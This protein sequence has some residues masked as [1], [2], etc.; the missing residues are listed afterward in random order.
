LVVRSD[1]PKRRRQ[2][3]PNPEHPTREEP[4]IGWA[5]P[6]I[7]RGPESMYIWYNTFANT[8]AIETLGTTNV[9]TGSKF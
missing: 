2:G 4:L 9:E 7:G 8:P 3:N 6:H 1:H 5:K